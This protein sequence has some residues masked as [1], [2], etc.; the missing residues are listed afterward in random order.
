M[1]EEH[2]GDGG[3]WGLSLVQV[4]NERQSH[5]GE[6]TVAEALAYVPGAGVKTLEGGGFALGDAT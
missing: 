1:D 6:W 5:S 4:T 3:A 2:Q